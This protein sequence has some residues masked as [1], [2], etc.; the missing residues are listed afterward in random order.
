MQ[1]DHNLTDTKIVSPAAK[2]DKEMGKKRNR[3]KKSGPQIVL[4]SLICQ[5]VFKG[6]FLSF[7]RQ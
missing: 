6:F 2:A 5:T 4:A 7:S 3:W 1:K